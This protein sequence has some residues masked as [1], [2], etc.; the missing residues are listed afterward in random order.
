MQITAAFTRA[1]FGF[2]CFLL[3]TLSAAAA[4]NAYGLGASYDSTQSNIIFRVYSLRAMRIEVD[5]YASPRCYAFRLAL[6][7]VPISFPVRF[8]LRRCQT[9][10][11][12]GRCITVIE[13]GVRTGLFR[14]VGPRVPVL[15]LFRTWTP[16]A[17]ASTPTSCLTMP[18]LTNSTAACW[19]TD[20]R[21][22][23]SLTTGGAAT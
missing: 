6:T 20:L 21:P 12:L 10:A 8:R 16:K 1:L 15:V 19:T 14:A 4:I 11:S 3:F 22:F 9:P 17:I 5:L 7:A 13:P 18:S 23:T 2:A